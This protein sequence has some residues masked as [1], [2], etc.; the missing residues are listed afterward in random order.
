MDRV[1][2]YAGIAHVKVP[3]ETF[4]FGGGVTVSAAGAHLMRPFLIT[5]R[6]PESS[7]PAIMN[8][9]GSF[10]FDIVAQIHI[11]ESFS[12]VAWLDL[13]KTVWWFAALLRMKATPRL[14]VP[15]V[16]NVSFSAIASTCNQQFW[17][18]EPEAERTWLILDPAAS[19]I[20]PIESLA[21]VRDHWRSAGLLMRSSREFNVLFE[22][23]DQSAQARDPMLALLLMWSAL[24]TM[25]SPARSELRFR[26]STNIAC[27]LEP[28]GEARA[29][30]QRSCAKLYDT[31]SA[32]AHGRPELAH[33]PLFDTYALLKRIIMRIIESDHVPNPS[34]LEEALF[35]GR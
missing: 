27:Y 5:H 32:A 26:V 2:I 25:F 7:F 15:V 28:P 29:S 13:P 11:S 21:W 23:F 6:A 34:E 17:P 16:S 9:S 20:I 18:I 1:P 14:R 35:H 24:E 31:R 4:D 8:A 30:L 3:C 33:Q 22:A 19:G 10:G 12:A